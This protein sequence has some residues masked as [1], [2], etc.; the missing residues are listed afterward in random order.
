MTH[1]LH[2]LDDARLGGVTR[3]LPDH[4]RRLT[5]PFRHE[6]KVLDAAYRLPGRID[7]DIVVVHF[8]VNWAKMP[9]MAMLRARLGKR[10][11]IIAEHSYTEAYE[12]LCVPHQAR[13][14]TMLRWNF[15]LADR[16][17]AVSRAQGAWLERAGVVPA[18]R[19]VPIPQALDT[20]ALDS[21]PPVNRLPGPMRLG[22]YGRYVPQKGFDILIEAMRLV[23]PSVATLQ[24]GGLGPDFEALSTAAHGLPHVSVGGKVTDVAGFLTTVDAVVIPSRWEAYG[25]VSAEARAAGRPVLATRTDG[26]V[27]QID[28]AWGLL[29]PSQDPRALAEAIQ[30]M[31]ASDLRA[32]GEKARGSVVGALDA[33]I[34]GW[35]AVLTELTQ[36]RPARAAEPGALFV[37]AS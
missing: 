32:M 25:L 17:V 4:I 7:A 6:I 18:A 31:A 13:F 26:L 9:F 23:P 1:V 12:Q 10:P 5:G 21:V 16:V 29:C 11:M 2:L 34:A 8:T 3:G 35:R 24:I 30:V 15:A 36:P 14:R 37:R 27:E 33:T 19:L 28:P 20:S 22:T